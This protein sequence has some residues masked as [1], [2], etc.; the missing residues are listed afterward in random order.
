M[1]RLTALADAFLEFEDVD[2]QCSLAIGSLA[3]FAGPA[4]EQSEVAAAIAAR[5][6]LIPRY[7]QRLR[8]VPL[9]LAAPAWVD[10]PD[11][12]VR[13][14]L[15]L[16]RVPAPAGRAEIGDLFSTL[17]LERMDRSRPLWDCWLVQGL[18]GGRWG[19]LT[20]LHHSMADG[21]S[22]AALYYLMLDAAPEPEP[23]V[24]DTWAPE[25][26]VSALAFTAQALRELAT[27]PARGVQAL[28][29][30][31]AAPAR[32]A[33]TAVGTADGLGTLAGNLRPVPASSLTGPLDG[34]R[35]YVWTDVSLSSMRP[36]RQAFGVTVND[37]ALAAMAGAFRRLLLS[38]GEALDEHGLRALVPVSTRGPG[39]ITGPDNRVSLLLPYLPV[40]IPDPVA[41]LAVVHERVAELR[42]HHEVEAGAALTSAA[43]HSLFPLVA[44]GVR[45]VM[46]IPQR[47]LS[48]V[49]TNVPGPRQTLYGLGR[50]LEQLL[51]YVPIADRVR[52]STAMFSYRD[53][54]TFGVT[55][56]LVAN[57]DLDVLVDG[58]TESLADLQAAAR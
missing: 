48:T 13:R 39:E 18:P 23:P 14:H 21:V 37:I 50:E 27:S 26:P 54:L 34:R 1:E 31:V 16:A 28:G 41:R 12:D 11:F 20:K 9:G 44:Q 47:H 52:I 4:P 17:M 8:R 42:A 19:L 40:D 22:G 46:R 38:R 35:R 7:R 57:P 49:T 6:P 36:V 29:G 51:P 3:V 25:P 58:I 45:L 2:P 43:D 30:L 24:P 32:L 10:D 56:D 55:A 33:R 15:H 53:T 5:L